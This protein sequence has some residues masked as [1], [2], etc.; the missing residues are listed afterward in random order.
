[1][2]IWLKKPSFKKLPEGKEVDTE[3]NFDN[4]QH[5]DNQF[6]EKL[7][8]S[9]NYNALAAPIGRCANKLKIIRHSTD[10]IKSFFVADNV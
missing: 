1:M 4:I 2:K 7:Y 3:R 9:S 6:T 8:L 5:A 10:K